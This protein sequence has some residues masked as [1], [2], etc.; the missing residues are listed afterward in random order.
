MEKLLFPN[1][2]D[3]LIRIFDKNLGNRVRLA[4]FIDKNKKEI[5]KQINCYSEN[6]N[7]LIIVERLKA[8]ETGLM[9]D[10]IE[11]IAEDVSYLAVLQKALHSISELEE[12]QIIGDYR[13]DLKGNLVFET[14]SYSVIDY[15]NAVLGDTY[16]QT[17]GVLNSKWFGVPQ[18]RKRH[19]IVGV[20]RDL[21]HEQEIKLPEEPTN[22][23]EV[24]VRN[25]IDDLKAY[26]VGIGNQYEPVPYKKGEKLFP[27][28]D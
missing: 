10:K 5:I 28:L 13:R 21:L 12:N 8:I 27:H 17:S 19:I 15:A 25:A 20:R 24:T 16:M 14:N 6:N 7:D 26:P 18:D 11:S 3:E 22:Y 9:A 4:R 23:Q 2:L 1:R